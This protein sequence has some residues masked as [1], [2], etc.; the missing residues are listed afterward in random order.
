MHRTG[1][2]RPEQDRKGQD[3]TMTIGDK[4]RT[5]DRTS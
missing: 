5:G 4:D 2:D 3:R 1:Q